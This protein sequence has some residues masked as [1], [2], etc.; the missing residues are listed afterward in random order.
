MDTIYKAFKDKKQL[1]FEITNSRR[2]FAG[3]TVYRIDLKVGDFF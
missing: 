2:S 1:E 3:Y